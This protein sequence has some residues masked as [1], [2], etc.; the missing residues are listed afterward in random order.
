MKKIALHCLPALLLT[1]AVTAH[2]DGS[3]LEAEEKA[4]ARSINGDI[5]TT[6][7]FHN[8]AAGLRKIYWLDYDGQRKF[9]MQLAPQQSYQ[10]S[11]YLTHPWLVTDDKDNALAL[12]YPDAQLR[13]VEIQ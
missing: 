12:Y 3:K 2:A 13:R 4:A 11:T 6:V 7:E 5:T 1:F 9:Y 10:Q 8:S